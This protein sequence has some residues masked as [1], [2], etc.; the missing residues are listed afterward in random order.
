MLGR[1]R[2]EHQPRP[3]YNAEH[4]RQGE[5]SRPVNARRDSSQIAVWY[6]VRSCMRWPTGQLLCGHA[7]RAHFLPFL[8][9]LMP[10]WKVCVVVFGLV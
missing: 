7:S 10:R 8:V 6:T 5:I 3:S 2:P 9:P 4:A 1:K